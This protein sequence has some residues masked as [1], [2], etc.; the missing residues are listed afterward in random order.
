MD[1]KPFLVDLADLLEVDESELVDSFELNGDNWDSV[2]V[3]STIAIIDEH[4]DTTVDGKSLRNCS[5]VGELKQLIQSKVE[6]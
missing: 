1:M 3:V 5:S 6:G 2:A 4:F